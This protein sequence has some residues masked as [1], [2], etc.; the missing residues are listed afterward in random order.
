MEWESEGE[1]MSER[2]RN[3]RSKRKR[4]GKSRTPVGI[5]NDVI[6]EDRVRQSVRS[7]GYI[8]Y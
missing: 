1:R 6:F 7:S 3:Q 4:R 8:K 2:G 5:N